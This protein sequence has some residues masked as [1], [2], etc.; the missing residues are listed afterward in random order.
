MAESTGS[1]VTP[2]DDHAP[3]PRRRRRPDAAVVDVPESSPCQ[4]SE[5]HQLGKTVEDDLA[6]VSSL[7]MSPA[8]RRRLDRFWDTASARVCTVRSAAV[9]PAG[10]ESSDSSDFLSVG[11]SR[12]PS[13]VSDGQST[14]PIRRRRAAWIQ[15]LE[16]L[17]LTD[18]TVPRLPVAEPRRAAV[19]SRAPFSA[20][21]VAVGVTVPTVDV[22]VEA[23]LTVV[24]VAV[25]TDSSSTPCRDTG[26]DPVTA[27]EVAAWQLP[28][29][30]NLDDMATLMV[31]RPTA[32][33]ADL[34]RTVE[35]TLP[36][37]DQTSY[38]TFAVRL[39]FQAM[40]RYERRLAEHLRSITMTAYL[41]DTT[42]W[43]EL[44]RCGLH[45]NETLRR[46]QPS[47]PTSEE[48]MTLSS[49]ED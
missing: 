4:P 23:P 24:D 29:A 41:E 42:G 30:V 12:P 5:P 14:S 20:V 46:N 11:L 47:A 17:E 27:E 13:D 31:L 49:D 6:N 48:V 2:P 19:V 21:D 28:P 16:I 33:L 10:C 45:L 7:T 35:N 36:R 43:T 1:T 25:D 22:E 15:P 37:A 26:S 3:P 32:T 9:R 38:G 44:R 39:A 18:V 8:S 34:Q 40:R